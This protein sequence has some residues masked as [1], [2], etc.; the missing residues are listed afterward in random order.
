[1]VANIRGQASFLSN[2]LTKQNALT[3]WQTKADDSISVVQVAGN[4][5]A[6]KVE[7]MG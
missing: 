6:E 4:T 2:I 7:Q 1:V 3:E 5:L